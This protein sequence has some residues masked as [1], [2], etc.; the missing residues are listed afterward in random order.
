MDLGRDI[1]WELS[2]ALGRARQRLRRESSGAVSLPPRRL[3]LTLD[4][5]LIH[6][7]KRAGAR[8]E[9]LTEPPEDW[10]TLAPHPIELLRRVDGYLRRLNTERISARKRARWRDQAL[11]HACPALRRIYSDQHKADALPESHDRR[12]GLTAGIR[13]CSQLAT[14]FK[15][16][17]SEDYALPDPRFLRVRDR[18]RHC[19]LRALELIRMEQRLRAMRYQRLPAL[20]WRDCNGIYF[21]LAQTEDVDAT[22]PALGC[23]QLHAEWM[24]GDLANRAVPTASLRRAYLAIQLFGLMDTNTVST[25]ELHVVDAQINAVLDQVPLEPDDGGPLQDGRLIVYCNQDRAPY[26]QR[27]DEKALANWRRPPADTTDAGADAVDDTVAAAPL[28]AP[29]ARQLDI[30]PLARR[31]LGEHAEVLGRFHAF[32]DD[33]TDRNQRGVDGEEGAGRGAEREKMA[34]DKL[35]LA[36]LLA[37]DA[38][39]EQLRPQRRSAPRETV[40]GRQVLYVYNGYSSVFKLLTDNLQEDEEVLE[41]L[42]ADNELRDT[43]AGRSA[44]ISTS[45]VSND[46]G[47]WFVLDRSDGGVHIKTRESQFTTGMFIGQLMAF[48][49]SREDLQRPMLGYVMRMCRDREKELE[50]TVRIVS[51]QPR[52]AAVQSEFLSQNDMALP[53]I[54]LRDEPGGEATGEGDVGPA[55]APKLLL[56]H[57]HRMASG[58]KVGVE[59]D[60]ES[61]RYHVGDLMQMQ[62]EFVIYRLATMDG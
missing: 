30:V 34:A 59:S 18:V 46:E 1:A 5:P 51:R 17:L 27:Q 23:L 45:R 36:R 12:E 56:H 32:C 26:F 10:L 21:A 4:L 50:V 6:Q 49:F 13:V 9:P 15:R 44:L 33:E 43:L 55:A 8:R 7:G 35:D 48:A 39:C 14:A 22:A 62:R 16:Q 25:R 11:K 3:P 54:L 24:P 53:A 42:A 52:P 60:G 28:Q 2:Y 31:V 61:H 58:L 57:S 29:P 41:E 40:I 38:M 19:G 20:A 47:Q 37:L